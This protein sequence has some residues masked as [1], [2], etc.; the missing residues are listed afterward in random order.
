MAVAALLLSMSRG[1]AVVVPVKAVHS[2]STRAFSRTPSSGEMLNV[3][4]FVFA[5]APATKTC[6]CTWSA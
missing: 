2:C 3:G 6:G 5:H 4:R 1:P